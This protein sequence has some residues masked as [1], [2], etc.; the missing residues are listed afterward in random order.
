MQ[1]VTKKAASTGTGREAVD[2]KAR[3]RRYAMRMARNHWQLYILLVL[4]IIY[5]FIFKYMP[6]YGI[7]IAFKQYNLSLGITGSEWVGLKWFRMFFSSQQLPRL[8]GNTIS[9]SLYQ[10]FASFIPPIVIAIALN[11]MRNA[12]FK[13]TV[14]LISYMPHFLSV[15]VICGILQQ[16]LSLNGM[17][18][19]L[20]AG[21]GLERIQFLGRPNMFKHIY[22]WSGI[23]Q[24]VGYNAIIYIAALSGISPELHEA[25]K[26]DGAT[27]WQRI[28]NV[29]IPGIL[30][31]AV[32]LLIM[33]SANILSV[34]FEKVFLLQNPLNTRASDVISTYVYRI[35][36]VNMEYSLSTA[37]GLFQSVVSLTMLILVNRISRKLSDTSLW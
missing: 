28:W 12:F 20:L 1:S 17:V 2:Q 8:L 36:M 32:I 33:N 34:G 31:T 11:E 9:I 24:N 35:G 16:V 30:P 15:V 22:V 29:D 19:N 13:K 26:V 25:A 18:N 23:W 4:P 10:L 27:I 5:I 6:M 14:Q 21:M 7:Q 37:V 3:R